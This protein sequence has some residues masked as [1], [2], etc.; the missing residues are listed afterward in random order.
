MRA[1]QHAGVVDQHVQRSAAALVLGCKGPHALQAG[2]VTQA[3][4]HVV[5]TCS[6]ASE[7]SFQQMSVWQHQLTSVHHRQHMFCKTCWHQT[8]VT[9]CLDDLLHSL[10][11]LL[12]LA[13][14]HQQ[15]AIAGREVLNSP[16]WMRSH[17]HGRQ[18]WVDNICQTCDPSPL[19]S[20]LL[21]WS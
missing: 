10:L 18:W 1:H 12:F 20:P 3:Q 17:G 14:H 9:R 16:T 6:T 15:G 21:Q 11:A 13:A 8:A 4:V 5:I 7:F 19:Q 2:D